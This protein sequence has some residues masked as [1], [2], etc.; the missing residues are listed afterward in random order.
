MEFVNCEG[1]NNKRKGENSS[2]SEIRT[3]KIRT[4]FEYKNLNN[5]KEAFDESRGIIVKMYDSKAII[6]SKFVGEK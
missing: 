6:I 4:L 1:K 2:K 3:D 5:N